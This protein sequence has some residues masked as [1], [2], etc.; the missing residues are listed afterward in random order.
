M[1]SINFRFEKEKLSKFRTIIKDLCRINSIIKLKIEGNEMSIYSMDT[2]SGDSVAAFK[3]YSLNT[4]D[5]FD[6]EDVEKEKGFRDEESENEN[7]NDS[8]QL[9]LVII[10]GKVLDKKLSFLEL[11]SELNIKGRFTFQRKDDVV[12]EIIG[13]Y[14]NN[15]KFKFS[16]IGGEARK[17]KDI[18][19]ENFLSIIDPDL[20][21]A[22]FKVKHT[23]FMNG[24]K[25]S[26][27][28]RESEIITI[29]LK[30]GNVIIGQD[31]WDMIVSSC[32]DTFDKKMSFNKKYMKS[33]NPTGDEVN[34]RVYSNFL[35][36]Y[37]E[38]QTF[39]VSFEVNF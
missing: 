24:K 25:A 38:N 4:A 31:T 26:D 27:I 39:M 11:N 23:D 33:M 19:K 21:E 18:P 2:I 20:S 10:D 28:D 17:I 14:M 6:I 36:Y 37:D 34:M 15:G 30:K 32:D 1:T 8:L 35:L 12:K 22:E 13:L 5:Y 3:T 16:I 29:T 9:D 7:I